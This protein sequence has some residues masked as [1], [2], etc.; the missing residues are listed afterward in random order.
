M[1][2]QKNKCVFCEEDLSKEKFRED[3]I[4]VPWQDDP[5]DLTS[6]NKVAKCAHPKCIKRFLE[7]NWDVI[8]ELYEKK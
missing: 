7:L 6:L 8:K 4:L 1:T 5:H 3:Y 2:K